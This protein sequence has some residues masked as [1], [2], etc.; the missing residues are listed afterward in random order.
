[1]PVAAD[2]N[3]TVQGDSA[4]ALMLSGADPEG[5]TLTFQIVQLPTN[6][7]ISAFSPSIGTLNYTPAHVFGGSDTI[8]FNVSDGMFT[9]SNA[10]LRITVLRPADTDHD[11]I[12]DYWELAHSL[13]YTDLADAQFDTDHDGRSN[14]QEYIANTDPRQ[15]NS[16]F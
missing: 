15:A 4:N 3:V 9:S 7:L 1:P 6:G 5:S 11:G 16:I 8:V 14:L 10:A 2:A 12:P 13:S